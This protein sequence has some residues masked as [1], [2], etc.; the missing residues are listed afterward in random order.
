MI[1][2]LVVTLHRVRKICNGFSPERRLSN[3][4]FGNPQEVFLRRGRRQGSRTSIT[5]IMFDSLSLSFS[6]IFN[7]LYILVLDFISYLYCN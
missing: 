4:G 5:I 3:N 6:Y 2:H 1:F 7:C